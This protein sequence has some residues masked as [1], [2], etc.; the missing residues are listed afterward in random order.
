[1]G[2]VDKIAVNHLSKIF[3]PHPEEAL[4]LLDQG[5]HKDEIFARTQNT[6]GV[7]D[8][9]L[10]VTA[11]EVFV[12]MGLSGSGK[13][14][15]VRMLNRLIE[16]TVGEVLI[17]GQDITK[18][19][20]KELVEHRR[21]N[22]AMVFQSFA[23][24]PHL[25]AVENA[26]FGLEVAGI[27]RQERHERAM[28]VLKEVN[29]EGYADSYPDELSGGMQQ[30]VGLARALAVDPSILLMDEAYS[31]LDPLIRRE[32]QEELLELQARKERTVVFISHD[33][34]EAMRIGDRIAMMEGGAVTQIGTPREILEDPAADYIRE[35][36]QDVDVGEVY[37]AEHAVDERIVVFREDQ[38][39]SPDAMQRTLEEEGA[40]YGYVVDGSE[41][42][43]GVVSVDALDTAEHGET[44]AQYLPDPPVVRSGT[45]LGHILGKVAASSYPVPVVHRNGCFLG[46]VSRNS[47]LSTLE[48]KT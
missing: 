29:L 14:T 15:L 26:A 9:S 4:D 36:F 20:E 17:D 40:R 47:L 3:G 8:V 1:M 38:A 31:A 48:R 35:F 11:G 13:S 24:L 21:K 28:E 6:V 30:R 45:H 42:F 7:R 46:A 41:R 12:V 32:M 16:P 39:E 22:T 33:L 25:T 10:S 18:M 37:T 43:V 27:E 23:L 19:S 2:P 5:V 34:D 44:E